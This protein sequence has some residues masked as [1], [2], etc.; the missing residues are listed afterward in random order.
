MLCTCD[1]AAL[2]RDDV[3]VDVGGKFDAESALLGHHQRGFEE[4]FSRAHTVTPLSI[5]GLV[6]RALGAVKR[7][8]LRMLPMEGG[9]ADR[10]GNCI[11]GNVVETGVKRKEFK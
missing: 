5:T 2:E 11:S 4:Y 3:V 7:H 8:C 6:Y 9:P 1:P 10:S